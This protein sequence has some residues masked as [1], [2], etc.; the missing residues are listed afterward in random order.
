M[1]NLNIIIYLNLNEILK[2]IWKFRNNL[3][4]VWYT[5]Q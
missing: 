5:Q 2:L 1:N 4:L 3:F